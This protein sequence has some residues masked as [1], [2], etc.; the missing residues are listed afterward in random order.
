MRLTLPVFPRA[1]PGMRA[2][3]TPSTVDVTL[4]GPV[5]SIQ[6]INVGSLRAEVDLLGFSPGTY[7][8]EP[9]IVGPGLTGLDIVEIQPPKV[10]VAITA[11]PTATPPP[12]A[13]PTPTVT[14]TR[15]AASASSVRPRA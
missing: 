14:P 5:P 8:V 4:K 3:I 2:Q 12:A 9:K 6:Q 10:T 13:T 7:Q 11:E 1:Q 15:P